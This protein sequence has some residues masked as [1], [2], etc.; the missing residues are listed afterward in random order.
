V[1]A[2]ADAIKKRAG[3]AQAA[4]AAT[5]YACAR[6]WKA[7][8]VTVTTL[9]TPPSGKPGGGA[10]VAGQRL[11][12]C[13]KAA[14]TP[15]WPPSTAAQRFAQELERNRAKLLD[16]VLRLEIVAGVDGA[17]FAASA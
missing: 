2:Q 10:A 9:S 7:R 16:E 3:A 17:E 14:S 13:C 8:S 11:R 5:S 1:Q 15:P 4:R 6:R 12:A